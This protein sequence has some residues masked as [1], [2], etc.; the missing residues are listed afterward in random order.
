[1]I[2]YDEFKKVDLRVAKILT[3]ERVP[4]SDKLIKLQV[5][6][7]EDPS[8]GSGQERQIIAGIGKSYG[9]ENLVGKE[10]VI[11]ANLEPRALMGLESQGMLLAADNEGQPVLLAPDA[12]IPAGSIVK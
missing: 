6:L 9:A 2:S 10:I 5:S 3:A 11:V 12:E 8:T 4:S 1:M 7:G